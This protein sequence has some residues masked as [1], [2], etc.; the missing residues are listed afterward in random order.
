MPKKLFYTPLFFFLCIT[1]LVCQSLGLATEKKAVD[2]DDLNT[3][4]KA[5]YNAMSGK[6]ADWFHWGFHGQV[7][8][9][10]L[11]AGFPKIQW[12]FVQSPLPS[13]GFPKIQWPFVYP[14][15]PSGGFPKIQW[16]FVHPPL[17]SGGFPKIQGPFVHPPLPS[18]GFQVPPLFPWHP[19][20]PPYMFHPHGETESV[21]IDHA[22]GD[23]VTDNA[24][25][26]TA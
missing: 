24:P 11:P 2:D 17:P 23:V 9:P 15:L 3:N 4:V 8:T 18:G 21:E 25:P 12:P 7:L 26:P 14:P 16:P 22:G 6:E 19:W 13:G 5:E 10:P 1:L 20:I